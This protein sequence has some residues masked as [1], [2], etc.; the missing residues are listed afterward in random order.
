MKQ[1]L[2]TQE[3]YSG[4]KGIQQNNHFYIFF[5]IAGYPLQTSLLKSEVMYCQCNMVLE[6]LLL[7]RMV[8]RGDFLLKEEKTNKTSRERPF[9]WSIKL[10]WEYT[11]PFRFWFSC[12]D[13]FKKQVHKTC[14]STEKSFPVCLFWR[15][16]SP[17]EGNRFRTSYTHFF[18]KGDIRIGLAITSSC[19]V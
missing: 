19:K 5:C 14:K 6:E 2:T 12:L 16:F 17:S 7:E 11:G 10:V 18:N 3:F 4:K 13:K 9:M 15:I 1:D 8:K